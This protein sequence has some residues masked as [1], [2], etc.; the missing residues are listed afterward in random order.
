MPRS[1]RIER[2][3]PFRRTAAWSRAFSGMRVGLTTAGEAID[4]FTFMPR[5]P[6]HPIGSILISTVGRFSVR[7]QYKAAGARTIASGTTLTGIGSDILRFT[8][9]RLG[10]LTAGKWEI[11]ATGAGLGLTTA[12]E[13]VDGIGA[14]TSARGLATQLLISTRG[15]YAVAG[16]AGGGDDVLAFAPRK[17]GQ[18]SITAAKSA[19]GYARYFDGDNSG[20]MDGFFVA[21][22]GAPIYFS[23]GG[24]DVRMYDPAANSITPGILPEAQLGLVSK[25]IRGLWIRTAPP[26]TAIP[27]AKAGESLPDGA[28]RPARLPVANRTAPVYIDQTSGLTPAAVRRIGATLALINQAIPSISLIV[29][30]TAQDAVIVVRQG[31]LP[32]NLLALAVPSTDAGQVGGEPAAIVLSQQISWYTGRSPR[33]IQSAQYDLQTAVMHEL[34]HLLGLAHSANASSA[35]AETL[36]PGAVHRKPSAHDI[37]VLDHLFAATPLSANHDSFLA[38]RPGHHQAISMLDATELN[39]AVARIYERR[40]QERQRKK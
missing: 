24:A 6:T 15:S 14:F 26:G 39:A 32:P 34:A 27:L 10:D 7:Q 8:P 19:G 9:T 5:D 37:A 36:K 21:A 3:P 22:P 16:L 4:A 30:P 18:F 35:L 13:N 29:A 28:Q 31:F 40:S 2:L 11:F 23:P 1:P 20:F 25:D 38:K 12:A 17:P 33:R